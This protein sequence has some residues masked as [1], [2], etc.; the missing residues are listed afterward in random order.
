MTTPLRI[1]FVSDISCPWCAIGLQALEQAL[2]RVGDALAVELHFQPFE[3]NPGMAPEGEDLGQHL[4]RKYR[5]GDAE[6]AR[7]REQIRQ[8]GEALGLV[9]RAAPG[10]RI[11]NTF[12]A[13]RL[14]HWAGLEG[15]QRALK[16][17]LLRT[18]F[19]EGGNP[20]DPATLLAVA[21]AVGLD[22][23]RARQLLD[24]DRYAAEVRERQRFYASRGIHAVPSIL[25]NE[26]D[27]IQG[28]Q[29]VQVFEQA[30]RQLAAR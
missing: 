16:H 1:D 21:T 25:F 12:D 9:F 19:S 4:A 23:E 29:P 7:N 27:L 20:S 18:C 30:L 8:R 28:G 26:R 11:Y 17:A 10:A 6:I 14:L 2:A 15:K 24:S 5:I 13:H 3:L 22:R